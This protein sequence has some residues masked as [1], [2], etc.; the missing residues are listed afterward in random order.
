LKFYENKKKY[1]S[2][3]CARNIPNKIILTCVVCGKQYSS[4]PSKKSLSKC[5][6]NECRNKLKIKERPIL[7]CCNCGKEFSPSYPSYIKR[8]TDHPACSAKC[9]GEMR[10]KHNKLP[11]EDLT[12]S[13]WQIIRKE[14]IERDGFQCSICSGTKRLSVHHIIPWRISKDNSPD[15]LITLCA[16]CHSKIEREIQ[17]NY[18]F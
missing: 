5:C 6:S 13:S 11:R 12:K 9:S 17:K 4:I 18:P 1:C 14:I 10:Q 16:S 8:Y 2:G 3:K 7:I 15:N